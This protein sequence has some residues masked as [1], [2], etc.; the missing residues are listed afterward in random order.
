MTF[1][2]STGMTPN[3]WAE[4]EARRAERHMRVHNPYGDAPTSRTRLIAAVVVIGGL[5]LLMGYGLLMLLGVVP[6]P[7]PAPV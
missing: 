7:Q 6:G 2:P 3:D 4:L 1:D 5:L